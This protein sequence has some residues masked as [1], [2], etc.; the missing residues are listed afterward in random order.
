MKRSLGF[1]LVLAFL[2][3]GLGFLVG[4]DWGYGAAFAAAVYGV[5]VSVF[6]AAQ[7]YGFV[8]SQVHYSESVENTKFAMLEGEGI[9]LQEELLHEENT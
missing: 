3:S 2:M 8:V 4:K 9:F 6:L 5:L 1:A 7:I